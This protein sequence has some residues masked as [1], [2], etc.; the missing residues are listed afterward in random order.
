MRG[1]LRAES[2]TESIAQRPYKPWYRSEVRLTLLQLSIMFG[3]GVSLVDA[4]D[5]LAANVP[6]DRRQVLRDVARRLESG[7][8]LSSSFAQF[9]DVFPKTVA[10]LVKI[11]EQTGALSQSLNRASEWLETQERLRKRLITVLT[12]PFVVVTVSFFANILI[13]KFCLPQLLDMLTSFKVTPPLLS[14]IVFGVGALVTDSRFLLF[15]QGL[16]ILFGLLRSRIFTETRIKALVSFALQLPY[17]GPL[18]KAAA[19]ARV[20]HTLSLGLEVGLNTVRSLELSLLTCGNPVY[21]AAAPELRK[22]IEF[23]SSLAESFRSHPE[24]F[25]SLFCQYLQVGEDTGR[26]AKTSRAMAKQMEQDVE[27]RV[28]LLGAVLEPLLLALSSVFVG[29][30]VVATFLPIQQFLS[31]LM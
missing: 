15:A 20:A 19:Q 29:L 30:L 18:I 31:R 21:A 2:G 3:S 4:L 22:S 1:D 26:I 10:E 6:A 13:L 28:N 7:H 27:H 9:P 12:Y 17:L 23:G 5:T 16:L 14:R 11:G 25:S 8:N 24:L